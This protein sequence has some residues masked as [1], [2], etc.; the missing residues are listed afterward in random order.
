MRWLNPMLLV[1]KSRSGPLPT[2]GIEAEAELTTT[3]APHIHKKDEDGRRHAK[4]TEDSNSDGFERCK[5][6]H[7]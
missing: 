6:S 1:I 4:N 5:H 2:T 7:R 3:A